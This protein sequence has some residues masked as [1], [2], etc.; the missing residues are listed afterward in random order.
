MSNEI[1]Q[2]LTGVRSAQ[3]NGISLRRVQESSALQSVESGNA[4][5]EAG[6]RHPEIAAGASVNDKDLGGIAGKLNDYTQSVNRQLQFTVD[7]DS[8]KTMIKVVDKE[9]GETI[10]EIPSEEVLEMQK[11]LKTASEQMFHNSEAGVA[12][13]FQGKA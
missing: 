10:R 9:T 6:S 1:S 5:V 8:G 12:L 13:L 2:Y 11:H 4:S 7:G 3:T